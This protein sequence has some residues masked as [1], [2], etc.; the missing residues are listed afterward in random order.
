M[1]CGGIY[2]TEN[3][4]IMMSMGEEVQL[5]ALSSLSV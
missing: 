3:I 5:K 1:M 4:H 2:G